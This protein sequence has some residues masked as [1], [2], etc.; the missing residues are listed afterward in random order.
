MTKGFY[1]LTS[2]ILSQ[3]RRLDVIGNNMTNITTP[4]YK[5]ETYTDTTFE[6][7]LISR[8]GNS[9]KSESEVL[10]SQSYMLATDR[11]YIDLSESG[12]DITGLNLDFAIMGEGYFG[13]QTD[14]GV[15]YTRGGSFSLDGEGYLYAPTHGRVL[16]ANGEGIQLDTDLI[17]SDTQGR[18]F[19]AET[20]EQLGQLGVFTFEDE[21]LLE[22][23]TSGLFGVGG[24]APQVGDAQV[25]WKAVENSNVDLANEMSRML[26]AQRAL[27]SSSQILKIYDQLLTKSTTEIGKLG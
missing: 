8:I 17:T 26:T 22:K 6:N 13:I 12:L 19:N 2:G 21:T 27:Q 4:G 1:N 24:Q 7:V 3:T 18:I 25:M 10:G 11:L 9:D 15:E 16:G 14:E 20:G 23:N 5:T